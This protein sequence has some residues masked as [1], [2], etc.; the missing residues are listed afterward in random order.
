MD[1]EVWLSAIGT[2]ASV[3][4]NVTPFLAILERVKLNTLNQIPF[5]N[6]KINHLSQLLWLY[7]SIRIWSM[8]L[9]IVNIFTTVLSFI[10]LFLYVYKTGILPS[11]IGLYI[12]VFA[13]ITS[14]SVFAMSPENLGLVCMMLTIGTSTSTLE[15]VKNAA[16]KQD[17]RFVDLKMSCSMLFSATVWMLFGFATHDFA[18]WASNVFSVALAV[19]LLLTHFYYRALKQKSS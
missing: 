4:N 9:L 11:F 3:V 7:Y 5:N 8:G 2:A 12:G 13:V 17:Y 19:I 10:N 14:L 1:P 18:V 16:E 6:L 15:C